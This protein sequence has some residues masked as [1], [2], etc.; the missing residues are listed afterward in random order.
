ML[1]FLPHAI[2]APL[3]I[4]RVLVDQFLIGT[5]NFAAWHVASTG[6]EFAILHLT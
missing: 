2:A 3:R 1:V 5:R 4:N 6:L